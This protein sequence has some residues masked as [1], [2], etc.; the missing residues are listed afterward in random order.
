MSQDEV[1]A[2]LAARHLFPEKTTTVPVYEKLLTSIISQQLST[3]VASVIRERFLGLFAEG[4]P[5]REQLL[6]M[7]LETLRSVGLSRQKATYMLNVAEFFEKE[8]IDERQWAK[9]GDEEIIG[10][11]TKIKGVGRWTV[12]MNLM[13]NLNRPDVFPVDDLGIQNAMIA[14]YGIEGTKREVKQKMKTV[15]EPWRPFR[16]YASWYLWR[17][18]EG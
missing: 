17:S 8:K 4:Y 1:M 13:F 7:D 10:Y 6:S 15:A 14:L 12:Q 18:L 16:T 9:M 2:E 11:L 5:A 3:K